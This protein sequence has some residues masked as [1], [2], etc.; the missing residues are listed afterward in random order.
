MSKL[1]LSSTPLGPNGGS[2]DEYETDD[3]SASDVSSGETSQKLSNG[4]RSQPSRTTRKNSTALNDNAR[5]R[6]G[7]ESPRHDASN[8]DSDSNCTIPIV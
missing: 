1:L 2:T 8:S 3:Y 4:G 5:S 7:E 6:G